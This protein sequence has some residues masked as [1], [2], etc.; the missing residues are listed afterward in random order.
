LGISPE[1]VSFKFQS[2]DLGDLVEGWTD[3]QTHIAIEA[4]LKSIFNPLVCGATAQIGKELITGLEMDNVGYDEVI[5]SEALLSLAQVDPANM[6]RDLPILTDEEELMY[7]N[8][9][10][11]Y[12]GPLEALMNKLAEDITDDKFNMDIQTVYSE[13]LLGREFSL[14]NYSYL[15]PADVLIVNLQFTPQTLFELNAV[16]TF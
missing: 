12:Q 3:E 7:A 15:T 13:I 6:Y 14:Q 5:F 1:V 4:A 10:N 11:S 16:G 8:F 2:P 9:V